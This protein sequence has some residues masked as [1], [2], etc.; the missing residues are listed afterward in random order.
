MK[1]LIIALLAA[2]VSAGPVMS[3]KDEC[4]TC[5]ELVKT[6]YTMASDP[7]AQNQILSLI[8]DACTF[9]G[10]EASECKS[11]VE[12]Y[13]KAIIQLI[14]SQLS[15]PDQVC[16]EIGLC[17]SKTE[18]L[19]KI[20]M[21]HLH[22][23]PITKPGIRSPKD[24][25]ITC[26]EAVNT[27]YKFVSNPA[28]EDEIVALLSK[29]CS[30]FGAE[31]ATCEAVVNT[32]GK[33]IVQT[34]VSLLSDG[35][36]L[37]TEIGLCTANKV[38]AMLVQAAASHKVMFT[39]KK[40]VLKATYPVKTSTECVLCEFVMKELDDM[41]SKNSTQQ[42]IIQAVEKVCSILPSTIKSKC[43]QFVQ[44]YGPAL[45]EILEQEVSPKLVC[46]TLG[47]CANREHRIAMRRS[48]K[49]VIGSNETCEICTTV[50]TYLKAFLK[51]NAT[52]EEI[53]NFLEK[54]CNYLPSQI[55]SECNAIV[56][57]YGSTVLQ[58]I[59][60]TDPTT[61]CKEI[62]LCSA[63]QHVM[64]TKILSKHILKAKIVAKR[65]DLC[66][67]GAPYW[68]ADR[69]NAVNCEAVHFCEK[70]AWN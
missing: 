3:P 65:D 69:R 17:T 58:I 34:L 30:E 2:A 41:L 1:I 48:H 50:M 70:H 61:L 46:T 47:L 13:G 6:I 38:K 18:M 12:T 22:K 67:L 37:C 39:P 7:T 68:C 9:L 36:K 33:Q 4:T 29:V 52:D 53:V 59:A 60:N 56:S 8:K 45:I 43:D 54:V 21:R 16:K 49:L 27:V 19:K 57:E 64:K 40:H 51:N 31:K 35:K 24:E 32:F 14:L 28:I 26:Q 11:L 25:C 62:G 5:K 66:Y 20:V 42:E 44:E 55:A 63:N 15:N 10:P 23:T